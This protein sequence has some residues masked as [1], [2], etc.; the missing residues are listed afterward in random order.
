MEI[1]IISDLPVLAGA[2]IKSM[3][4]S[5]M[6]LCAFLGIFLIVGLLID[7]MEKKRNFWLM[8]SV[9][10]RGIYATALI[11]VPIHEIGHAIMCFIFGHKVDKIKLVQFGSPDGTMGYVNHS[12]EPTNLFHRIGLFFIGIAPIIM[13]IFII[14][15]AMFFILPETFESWTGAVASSTGF[16]D[17]AGTTGT[18]MT[19]M[20]SVENWANPWFYLFLVISV[21][22]ASHMTLSKSDIIGA[23]SGLVSMYIVLVILNLFFLSLKGGEM[24]IQELFLSE[25]NVF[26]L[27][28]SVIALLFSALASVIAFIL[29][30]FRG[31]TA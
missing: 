30:Q 11:G 18:L 7:R 1:S 25:Y 27:S 28:I 12:Y 16:S 23:K 22:I 6:Q 13:G 24:A 10:V 4:V 8:R 5:A 19:S 14:S 3:V 15:V 31:R 17:I 26:M 9:G 20:F 29:Y 2:F 21:S